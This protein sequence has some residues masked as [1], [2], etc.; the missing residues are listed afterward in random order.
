MLPTELLQTRER[1]KKP[2]VSPAEEPRSGKDWRRTD[3]VLGGRGQ[4][5]TKVKVHDQSGAEGWGCQTHRALSAKF[6]NVPIIQI[7][8]PEMTQLLS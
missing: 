2:S 5:E 3:R 6:Q 4:K 8:M 1:T 7:S